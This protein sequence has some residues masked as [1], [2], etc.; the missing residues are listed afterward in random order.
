MLIASSLSSPTPRWRNENHHR[1]RRPPQEQN[2]QRTHVQPPSDANTRKSLEAGKRRMA[3]M[4]RTRIIGYAIML[5]GVVGIELMCP[6][7]EYLQY[8]ILVT[9]AAVGGYIIGWE[10]KGE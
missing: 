1:Q 7:E 8:G 4:S 3:E 2:H 5:F 9:L 6:M 10:D